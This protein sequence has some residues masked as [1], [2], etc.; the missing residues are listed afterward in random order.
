MSM[1]TMVTV[2]AIVLSQHHF[3]NVRIWSEDNQVIGDSSRFICIVYNNIE[4]IGNI[5]GRDEDAVAVFDEPSTEDIWKICGKV[6][7]PF[8]FGY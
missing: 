5:W 6:G 7:L 1:K 2:S 4:V 3:S 8:H